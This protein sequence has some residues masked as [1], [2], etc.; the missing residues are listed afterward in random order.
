MNRKPLDEQARDFWCAAWFY[1]RAS[2]RDTSQAVNI[3]QQIEQQYHEMI[4]IKAADILTKITQG[5]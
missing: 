5:D 3:L 4:R 2:G 1:R